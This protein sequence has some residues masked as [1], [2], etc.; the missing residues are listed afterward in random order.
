MSRTEKRAFD[1]VIVGAGIGGLV[2]G[3]YLAKGGK[4]VLIVEQHHTP[5]GYC[6]SFRRK[7]FRFDAAANSLGGVTRGVLGAVIKE[8]QLDELVQ[9]TRFDPADIVITNDHTISFWNDIQH[10]TEELQRAFPEERTGFDEFLKIFFTPNAAVLSSFRNCTFQ[11]VLDKYFHSARL[12]VILATPLA[13]FTGA[14]PSQLSALIGY[15]VFNQQ[16]LDGG[17]YPVGGMQAFSNALAGR[18]KALGGEMRLSTRATKFDVE[19]GQIRGVILNGEERI[20][21]DHVISNCDAKSTFMDLLGREHCSSEMLAALSR[22]V[23]SISMYIAYLGVN[24]SFGNFLAPGANIWKLADYNL[25]SIFRQPVDESLEF[26]DY[27]MHISADQKTITA[28]TPVLFKDKQYWSERKS[29]ILDNFIRQI[30]L[31]MVPGLSSKLL[32]KDAATPVTLLKY[33]GNQR[34]S[35]YGWAPISSQ[36]AILEFRKP[37]FIGNLYLTGHW[38]T[39][40]AGIAGVS[41]VGRDTAKKLLKRSKEQ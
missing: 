29:L 25:E 6:T 41:Y 27:M 16:V 19:E 11:D 18:F 31:D 4:K 1:A 36:Y 13:C 24:D 30:E 32:Y 15:A 26:K 12:K 38:T 3:C 22:M 28:L 34:G 37:S 8:L 20:P 35:A 9:F 10:T 14:P 33:T 2:C 40:G 5:G 39:Y 17:Y 21:A 7:Q 23:P